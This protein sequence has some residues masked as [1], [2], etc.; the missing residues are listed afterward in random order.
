MAFPDIEPKI[1][2]GWFSAHSSCSIVVS[3]HKYYTNETGPNK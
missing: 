2:G 3:L 1:E